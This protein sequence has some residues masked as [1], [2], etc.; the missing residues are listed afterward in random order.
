MPIKQLVNL[1]DDQLFESI[2]REHYSALTHFAS[3]YVND[4]DEAEELV[5]Q[6]FT[7]LWAANESIE[8]TTSVKSYLYG[9]V[10]NACLNYIKHETVKRNHIEYAQ[11]TMT[12]SSAT[13]FLELD[14]LTEAIEKAYSKIPE[15]CLQVFQLSRNEG[16]KYHEIAE[17]QSVTVKTVEKQMSQALRILRTELKDYL[18]FGIFLILNGGKF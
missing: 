17:M 2:F 1:K 13:D 16:K 15:K 5:Q 4:P 6:M 10:R 18:F 14:E 3:Q 11:A 12:S 7:K 8:I 9:A